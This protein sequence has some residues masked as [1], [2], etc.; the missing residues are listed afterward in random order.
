VRWDPTVD[1]DNPP[2]FYD[3]LPS[4][5]Y[6]GSKLDKKAFQESKR[7]YYEAVGWDENGIPS[8][9]ELKHLGLEKVAKKIEQMGLY[10]NL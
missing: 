1:D 5:P 9:E 10:K 7:Q 6:A 4:G 8:V 2:R 3:S